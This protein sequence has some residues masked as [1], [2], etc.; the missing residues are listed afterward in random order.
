MPYYIQLESMNDLAR[1]A[2]ALEVVPSPI[3][4]FSVKIKDETKDI[5]ALALNTDR[6]IFCYIDATCTGEF[7]AYRVSMGNEEIST[8]NA[9]SNP[10]YSYI[11]VI[12]AAKMPKRLLKVSRSIGCEYIMLSDLISL[13]KLS[14]YRYMRDEILSPLFLA[15]KDSKGMIGTFM[16]SGNDSTIYFCYT[17]LESI[18]RENFLRYSIQ[19]EEKPMF[20]N[21]IDGHGYIYMKVVRLKSPLGSS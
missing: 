1:L 5:L 18:P 4:S 11:P 20:T 2:A 8:V 12:R 15:V 9:A 16:N 17:L 7:I 19:S 13:A 21:S 3:Y 14:V 10:A 6:L